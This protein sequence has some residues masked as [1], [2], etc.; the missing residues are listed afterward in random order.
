M[1]LCSPD[2]DAECRLVELDAWSHKVRP[3]VYVGLLLSLM[4]SF[5][6]MRVAYCDESPQ[7]REQAA[8]FESHIRPLLV[9]KCYACHSAQADEV[10]GGLWLDSREG[11]HLGGDSG[12]AVVPG[13]LDGSLLYQAISS[14]DNPMPPDAPLE[15]AEVEVVREW[16]LAGAFDPR[17]SNTAPAQREYDYSLGRQYWAF[18]PVVRPNIPPVADHQW[19]I[20]PIDH[21]ILQQL[22]QRGLSPSPVASPETLVRRLAFDLTGLPPTLAQIDAFVRNPTDGA[23]RQ[24]VDDLLD[25]PH[26]GERQAQHWLDL[27]RYA[28]T[29]GFEYDRLMPGIWRYRDYVINSFNSDKPYDQFLLEQLAGDELSADDYELRVAAGFH[30]LGAVRRNAGNQK[31]ASS[32]NEV[33]TERTDIIGSAILALTVGCARCHD[34]KF[35]P[36]SQQDYYR[37]QAYIGATQEA[38]ISLRDSREQ[39]ALNAVTEEIEVQIAELKEILAGASGDDEIRLAA[40]IKELQ[41]RLPAAGPMICSIRN[42][43]EISPPIYV[44]RR[45]DPELPGLMVGMRNLGVLTPDSVEELPPSTENPRLKLAHELIDPRH[46]LTARV[47]VN[48]VWLQHF[49]TGLVSTANDFGRN[50]AKPSHPELLDY[51]ADEFVA[52]GWHV[53]ALHR[54]IVT[55]RVYRQSSQLARQAIDSRS[56]SGETSQTVHAS[57]VI[58]PNNHLLSHFPRRRLSGEEI[59][60]ALLYATGLLNTQLGGESVLLPVARDLV[61]QLYDPEQWAVTD[62]PA[63]HYR[64]SIYLLAK[65]N[66]RHPFMEVFD[67]P[68]SQTSC[69]AREQ[70]THARQALELLNGPITNQLAVQFAD[71]L[72]RE[73]HGETDETVKLAYRLLAGREPYTRELALSREFIKN[74]GLSEFALAMFNLNA[75]LYVD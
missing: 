14:L 56:P 62:D 19:P 13:N 49:G 35:D 32:R 51:L 69:A 37:L 10:Q 42:D 21:F 22:E 17:E 34:H 57:E 64:R 23:Y 58:D 53:K 29:E 11:T 39:A 70:S 38:N 47:M 66:L 27:V 68:S 46:P 7:E 26:Y 72:T 63:L 48:R 71:R 25:S 60:D 6:T 5:H 54:A 67:Q 2:Q 74:V 33:L 41:K 18:Q 28:E 59:R 75:F 50:G 36:I 52:S 9:E 1:P 65:R 20:T 24:L 16:I 45:G 73:T 12:P 31:V 43:F 40:Q 3:T 4:A 55:S 61:D 44:L 30:R 8:F 15:V